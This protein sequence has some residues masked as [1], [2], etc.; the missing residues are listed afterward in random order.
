MSNVVEELLRKQHTPDPD[1][2]MFILV[3]TNV[4]D[5]S[6]KQIQEFSDA[7]MVKINKLTS[8]IVSAYIHPDKFKPLKTLSFVWAIRVL[9]Y[10]NADKAAVM[11]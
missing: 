4:S 10:G 3:L 2:L 5:L 8:N 11:S 6:E 9:H 1:G 7:G